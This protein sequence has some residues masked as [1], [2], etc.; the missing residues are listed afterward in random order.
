M[1]AIGRR[2]YGLALWTAYSRAGLPWEINGEIIRIDPRVRHLVPHVAEP[3]VDRFIRRTVRPGDLVLDV[4]AFLGIHA[5]VAARQAGSRGRVIAF[6]PTHASAEIARRHFALNGLGD[7]VRMIEA[8]VSDRPGQATFNEYS[9]PYVNSLKPAVDVDE[10]PST[11]IAP[12]VT[13]DDVC[14][15]IDSAPS[16]IRMDVQGAEVHALRG[17]RETIDR[18][19]DRLVLLVEMHPQCWPAFGVCEAQVRE[20]IQTLGLTASPLVPG[21]PLFGPD[22]HVV[23]TGEARTGTGEQENRRTQTRE[24]E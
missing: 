7:R 23:L 24:G 4:G 9:Q 16:L 2:V 14:R 1:I 12:I 10:S 6:E 15:R 18:A 11:R 19:G 5:I 22:R 8:A 17:A 3:E 21:E 13:I 20:T